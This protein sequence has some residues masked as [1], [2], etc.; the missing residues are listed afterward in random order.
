MLDYVIMKASASNSTPTPSFRQFDHDAGSETLAAQDLPSAVMFADDP[1]GDG[2]PQAGTAFSVN[3]GRVGTVKAVE[4]IGQVLGRDADATVLDSDG[5]G[6]VMIVL[7][8]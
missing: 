7:V 1:F 4:D 5:D 6:S 2:E 8:D 3:P